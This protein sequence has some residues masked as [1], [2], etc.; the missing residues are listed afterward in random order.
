MLVRYLRHGDSVFETYW[1]A[2]R[3]AALPA[4]GAVVP[5][6]S[7]HLITQRVNGNRILATP[8]I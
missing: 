6:Y 4:A 3:I 7:N 1:R 2:E 5:Q 8:L